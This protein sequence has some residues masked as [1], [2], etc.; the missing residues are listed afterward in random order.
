MVCPM[1]QLK[2]A[3]L[4]CLFPVSALAAPDTYLIDVAHSFPNFEVGHLGMST[5]RC[6][7]DLDLESARLGGA[8]PRPLRQDERQD[9]PGLTPSR[10]SRT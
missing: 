5:I 8:I 4:A 10:A 1:R 6:G 7:L 3:L 2:T 9:H